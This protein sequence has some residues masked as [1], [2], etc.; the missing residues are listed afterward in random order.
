MSKSI[1]Q[2]PGR[3]VAVGL[4]VLEPRQLEPLLTHPF[5]AAV[6]QRVRVSVGVAEFRSRGVAANALVQC[7]GDRQLALVDV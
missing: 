7:P 5:Q 6:E 3:I 1:S 2:Q 4:V